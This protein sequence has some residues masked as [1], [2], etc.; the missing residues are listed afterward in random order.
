MINLLVQTGLFPNDV[1]SPLKFQLEVD[2][3]R[4]QDFETTERNRCQL[5]TTIQKAEIFYSRELPIQWLVF[6]PLP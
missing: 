1:H 6:T 3:S 4:V 2:G 5:T